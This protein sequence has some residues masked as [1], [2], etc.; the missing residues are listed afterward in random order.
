MPIYAKGC[1]VLIRFKFASYLI[2]TQ[3]FLE[4][5]RVFE[6]NLII[7]PFLRQEIIR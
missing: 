7:V 6:K 3:S 4:Y 2:D 1:I 5:K